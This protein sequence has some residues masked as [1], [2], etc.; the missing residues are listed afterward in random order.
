MKTA[1]SVAT[2]IAAVCATTA[3][4]AADL[5]QPT[6]AV[7]LTVTGNI[8]NSNHG[9]EAK[10]DRAMLEALGTTKITTKTPWYEQAVTFEGVSFKA[11]MEYVGGEGTNVN[12]I[13]LNDYGTSIPMSDIQQTGMILAMKLNGQDMEVRDKGPIFVIYPYDSDPEYQTQTYYARSAWQV[14]KLIVE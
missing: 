9:D 8:T 5:P 13:A 3:S 2:L 7:I 14:T 11:L 10:F 4:I 12:A 6:G 1:C